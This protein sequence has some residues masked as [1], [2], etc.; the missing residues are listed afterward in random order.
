MTLLYLME[1]FIRIKRGKKRKELWYLSLIQTWT[2]Q[3]YDSCYGGLVRF[4]YAPLKESGIIV[5]EKHV[6]C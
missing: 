4:F 2:M 5:G 6:R 3:Y 1:S